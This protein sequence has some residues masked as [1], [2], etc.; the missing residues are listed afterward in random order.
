M[1]P[2]PTIRLLFLLL[3]GLVVA[4]CG[5]PTRRV[6][7]QSLASLPRSEGVYGGKFLLPP[8]WQYLGSDEKRH[9]FLYTYTRGNLAHSVRLLIPKRELEL[10]FAM[11]L[12]ANARPVAVEPLHADTG[13]VRGFILT[14]HT[15][16]AEWPWMNDYPPPS[17][18]DSARIEAGRVRAAEQPYLQTTR[19]SPASLLS[20]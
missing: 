10:A 18:D 14:I 7:L 15:K 19:V 12:S 16:P 11:P 20:S 3:L 13:Q 1:H 6:S 8:P 2:R 5:T 4:G 9:H 17:F